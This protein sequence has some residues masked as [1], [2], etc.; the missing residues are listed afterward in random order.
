MNTAP[1]PSAPKETV[2]HV[3][4][5]GDTLSGIVQHYYGTL[6]HSDKQEAIQKIVRDNQSV[7]SAHSIVAGELLKLE[8]GGPFC[9]APKGFPHHMPHNEEWFSRLTGYWA[10]ADK[11]EREL[12]SRISPLLLGSGTGKL[13]AIDRVFR[14]NVGLLKAMTKNYELYKLGEI[15]KGKYDYE[16]RK[17]V[18]ALDSQLG[19][20]RV[21]LNGRKGSSEILR[22]SRSATGAPTQPITDQI[23][24][25]TTLSKA[26]RTGGVVLSSVS[27]PITC[28]AI[29]GADTQNQKNEILVESVG[30][31]F[32]SG[33]YAVGTAFVIVLVGTPS[34][35]IASLAIAAGGV[36]VAMLSGRALTRMYTAGGHNID[37]AGIS[38]ISSICSAPKKESL[39]PRFPAPSMSGISYF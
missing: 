11:V 12:S 23:Q 26:A 20:A 6:S 28:S 30:A 27:L 9:H 2:V 32:G 17:L 31:A 22:I 34:G 36:L 29:A 13:Q 14:S 1:L 18:L 37:F 3:V 15:T 24:K 21:L 33:A 8:V 19:P 38:G 4:Q 16:R 25:M 10:S 7:K 39:R 5:P 35:W